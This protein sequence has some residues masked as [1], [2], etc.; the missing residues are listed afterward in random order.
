[1]DLLAG[2]LALGQFKGTGYG[3]TMEPAIAVDA[4]GFP[5]ILLEFGGAVDGFEQREKACPVNEREAHR[6]LGR[7]DITYDAHP[8][9]WKDGAKLQSFVAGGSTPKSGR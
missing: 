4:E 5:G 2:W 6:Y 9:P 3:A 1:M 7:R 8:E